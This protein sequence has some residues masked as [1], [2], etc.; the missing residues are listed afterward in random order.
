MKDEHYPRFGYALYK[1]YNNKLI[2]HKSTKEYD[3]VH[4]RWVDKGT[5]VK[6]PEQPAKKEDP[7]SDFED[8]YAGRRHRDLPRRRRQPPF[9]QKK[10]ISFPKTKEGK[11][12]M[13]FKVNEEN[14]K[15]KKKLIKKSKK[16]SFPE[17]KR[18]LRK[19]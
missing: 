4:H 19:R 13:R 17:K 6:I 12:D 16:P 11:P 8:L 3:M 5:C 7:D 15:W 10:S 2:H 9:Q 14:G 18:S 1:S